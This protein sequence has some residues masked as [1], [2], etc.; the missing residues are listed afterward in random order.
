MEDYRDTENALLGP[1]WLRPFLSHQYFTK[2]QAH[3]GRDRNL[4]CVDCTVGPLCCL[5]RQQERKDHSTLQVRK[6][7]HNVAVRTEELKR[8]V[9]VSQIQIY[10]INHAEIVYLD[11]RRHGNGNGNGNASHAPKVLDPQKLRREGKNACLHCC[12]TFSDANCYYCSISCKLSIAEKQL[13]DKEASNEQKLDLS[14]AIGA[15]CVW[16][17]RSKHNNSNSGSG[18]SSSETSVDTDDSAALM[19]PST[20]P[21]S[22]YASTLS[23]LFASRYRSETELVLGRSPNC[24]PLLQ[25]RYT[26]SMNDKNAGKAPM[27]EMR[28]IHRSSG[29][30]ANPDPFRAEGR[31]MGRGAIVVDASLSLP[32]R[33]C[34]LTLPS[35]EGKVA[36]NCCDRGSNATVPVEPVPVEPAPANTVQDP[37]RPASLNPQDV[38]S[39]RPPH[40]RRKGIPVRSPMF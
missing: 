3:G 8:Y 15:P 21:A 24:V 39:F 7:S 23:S 22:Q 2:C 36:S 14:V 17:G 10:N 37:Q 5:G 11:E 26:T 38:H 40:R 12:R 13:R 18:T 16:E 30:Y 1:S 31:E 29:L 27:P 9:N 33:G 19:P 20:A 35:A 25:D 32:V 28:H 6:A 4:F 34:R